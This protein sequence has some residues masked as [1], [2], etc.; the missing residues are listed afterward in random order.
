MKKNNFKYK[1]FVLALFSTL[2]QV[3]WAQQIAIDRGLKL[4]GICVFACN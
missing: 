4:E 3:S 2:S 1:W